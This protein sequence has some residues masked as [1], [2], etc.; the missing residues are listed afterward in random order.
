MSLVATGTRTAIGGYL[1]IYHGNLSWPGTSNL[2]WSA[3]NQTIA[4]TT[5]SSV[6]SQS[7]VN[8]YAGSVTDVVID[9]LGYYT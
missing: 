6:N 1:S 3:P 2:N 4:V 8:L 7:E 9:V 5:L